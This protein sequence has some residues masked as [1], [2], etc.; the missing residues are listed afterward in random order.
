MRCK[1]MKMRQISELKMW[2]FDENDDE[3]LMIE[4]NLT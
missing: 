1:L 4:L 2:K 3:E